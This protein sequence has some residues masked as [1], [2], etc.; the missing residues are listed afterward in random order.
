MQQDAPACNRTADTFEIVFDSKARGPCGYWIKLGNCADS[1]TWIL[2]LFGISW[3]PIQIY[4]FDLSKL[5][6][7]PTYSATGASRSSLMTSPYADLLYED[8]RIA[9]NANAKCGGIHGKPNAMNLPCLG[10][11]CSNLVWFFLGWFV[12]GFTVNPCLDTQ[13][14]TW[15]SRFSKTPAVQKLIRPL[16]FPKNDAPAEADCRCSDAYN[17]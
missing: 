9:A 17:A 5:F 3:H 1:F 15:S 14:M 16:L 2:I 6:Q 12:L 4:T 10:M 11:L 8:G 7:V 13:L